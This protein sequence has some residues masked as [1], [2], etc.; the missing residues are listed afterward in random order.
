MDVTASLGLTHETRT[1]LLVNISASGAR[2]RMSKPPSV[3]STAIFT[4]HLL[5]HYCKVVWSRGEECGLSFDRQIEQ[6]DMEG[7]L[8]IT[9]NRAQYERLN[10]E[11]RVADWAEGIGD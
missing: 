5:K 8:W 3:G 4:F 6:E 1:C 9:Q 11:S 7:M 2:V 10:Q